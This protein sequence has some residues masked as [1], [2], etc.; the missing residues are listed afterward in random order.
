M[1][2]SVDEQ[3]PLEKISVS[4]SE[5]GHSPQ[6][7]DQSQINFFG[8]MLRGRHFFLAKSITALS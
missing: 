8:F 5:G 4:I 6:H 7:H 3:Q 1:K 2:E